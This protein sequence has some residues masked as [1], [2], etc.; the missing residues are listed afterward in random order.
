MFLKYELYFPQEDRQ[1]VKKNPKNPGPVAHQLLVQKDNVKLRTT[2]KFVLQY[3]HNM[4]HVRKHQKFV[5]HTKAVWEGINPT[6]TIP[7]W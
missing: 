4:P 3:S 6:C 7:M 1:N 2:F 5:V